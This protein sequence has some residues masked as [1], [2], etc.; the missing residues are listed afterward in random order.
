MKATKHYW[1]DGCISV[2]Q[3]I[4]Q[5]TIAKMYGKKFPESFILWGKW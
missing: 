4:R 1:M 3:L 2:E 5:V